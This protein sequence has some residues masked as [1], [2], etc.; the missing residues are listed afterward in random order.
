MTQL[1]TRCPQCST[2]F[3]ITPAQI[4]KARGAVRCGSCL[5]IFNAEHNLIDGGTPKPIESRSKPAKRTPQ[6]PGPTQAQ[7]PISDEPVPNPEPAI[8]QPAAPQE[9]LTSTATEPEH[10]VEPDITPAATLPTADETQSQGAA[11]PSEPDAAS[12]LSEAP[13]PETSEADSKNESGGLLRFDQAQIDL[14]SELDDDILISDDMGAPPSSGDAHLYVAPST[15]DH[16]LF[17]RQKPQQQDE[18]V[19]DSDESWAESLLEEDSPEDTRRRENIN[20]FDNPLSITRET[21]SVSFE[22]GDPEHN[23]ESQPEDNDYD[24]LPQ[25]YDEYG[26]SKADDYEPDN[27]ATES[28]ELDTA[29]LD[30]PADEGAIK[31]D[32]SDAPDDSDPEHNAFAGHL[33]A[34]DSERSALLMGIDP[35]PVEM[36]SAHHRP[37]RKRVLWGSLCVLATLALAAQ[38]AWLQ[39]DRFSRIEPYRSYYQSA[40]QVLGCQLPILRDTS[41]VRAYNLVVRQHPE[42][43]DALMVDAIILNDAEFE[44][45]YPALQLSFS[46]INDKPVASRRFTPKEYLRGEL[47]GRSIMPPNQPVHLS[48]ELADPGA[49]AINYSLVIP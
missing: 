47:S 29:L 13:A 30:D 14:E 44:Q 49:N 39:V 12:E 17:E 33:R 16:S 21:P 48:L 15:N 20:T 1:V 5:H 24:E 6:A 26:G 32:R 11:P 34:Y 8:S 4:Q 45:P 23:D 41:K 10:P 38:V 3:R 46:D 35:E 36:A 43:S 9:N 19:D 42:R 18:F 7:L 25:T 28:Y 40:C 31:A 37:W 22:P 2:S 27:F